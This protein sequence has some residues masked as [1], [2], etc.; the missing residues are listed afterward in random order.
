MVHL[1]GAVIKERKTDLVGEPAS[2]EGRGSRKTG[3]E[4]ADA[5]EL[6]L[7]VAE[8]EPAVHPTTVGGVFH[9]MNEVTHGEAFASQ[10]DAGTDGNADLIYASRIEADRCG[11]NESDLQALQLTADEFVNV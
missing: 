5:G 7:G 1:L 6:G 4:W 9:E 10:H 11:G 8:P 3:D 2:A